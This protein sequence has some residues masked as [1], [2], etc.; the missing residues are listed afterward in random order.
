MYAYI[1]K[2]LLLKLYHKTIV[3]DRCSYIIVILN[4]KTYLSVSYDYGLIESCILLYLFKYLFMIFI[5]FIYLSI[6]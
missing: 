5:T 2:A 3:S 6:Y 4:K 1:Q